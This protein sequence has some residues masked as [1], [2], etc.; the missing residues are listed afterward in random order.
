MSYISWFW[1]KVVGAT[2]DTAEW[3]KSLGNAVAGALGAFLL[4]IFQVFIDVI[5]VVQYFV[6]QLVDILQNIAQIPSWLFYFLTGF[7]SNL[8]STT[9]HLESAWDT[10][11]IHYLNYI[12]FWETLST[13]IGF[14]LMAILLGLI[15]KTLSA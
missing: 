15:F 5:I 8:Q 2:A 7:F 13:A 9:L 3:F 14:A 10:G 12:P 11:I 4:P 1:G 6:Q